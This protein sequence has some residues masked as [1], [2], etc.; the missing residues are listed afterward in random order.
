MG[1]DEIK[2]K[3]ADWRAFVTK[4]VNLWLQRKVETD[5]VA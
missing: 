5:R 1:F 3:G 4:V 2:C